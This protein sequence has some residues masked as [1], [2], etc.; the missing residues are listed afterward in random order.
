MQPLELSAIQVSGPLEARMRLSLAH[1][2]A[3]RGRILGGE[4][5]GQAWG[6]DQYGRWIG[7]VAMAA[8]YTGQPLPA[9][10]ETVQRFL[11]TQAPNG[12]FG[13]AFNS[14]TWWGAGRGLIGLLEYWQVSHD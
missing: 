10:P 6:A 8:A 14:L 12:F 5:F 7:A 9:L 3:E 13:R 4:G 11:R 2:L 1:L